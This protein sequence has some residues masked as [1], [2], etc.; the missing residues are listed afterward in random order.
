[1]CKEP[2]LSGAESGLKPPF[3]TRGHGEDAGQK[4]RVMCLRDFQKEAFVRRNFKK[5]SAKKE[6]VWIA[7]KMVP[8]EIFGN[9]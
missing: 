7:V 9:I 2:D 8:G 6:I 3:A 5:C 4:I 1:M